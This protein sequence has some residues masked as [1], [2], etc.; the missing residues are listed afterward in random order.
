MNPH[1]LPRR[2]LKPTG[3]PTKALDFE[4]PAAESHNR[5]PAEPSNEGHVAMRGNAANPRATALA[6]LYH[7]A[8]ALAMAG[9]V[10]GA[11]ALHEAIGRMLGELGGGAP[12]VDLAAARDRR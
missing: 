12:V 7:H 6:S 8:A 5:E 10:A 9:D 11:R 4:E 2:N 1:E 3:T